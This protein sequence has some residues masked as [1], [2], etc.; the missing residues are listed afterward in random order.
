MR[1]WSTLEFTEFPDCESNVK[2]LFASHDAT[3]GIVL[4]KLVTKL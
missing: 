4:L 2:R 1:L 3:K